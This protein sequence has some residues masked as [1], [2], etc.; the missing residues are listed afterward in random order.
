ML[1]PFNVLLL[2]LLVLAIIGWPAGLVG[3]RLPPQ[4][5]SAIVVVILL[6]LLLLGVVRY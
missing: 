6:V 2:V 4:M 1:T 3:S 5:V